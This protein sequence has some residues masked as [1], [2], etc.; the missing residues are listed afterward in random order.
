MFAYSLKDGSALIRIPVNSG[1]ILGSPNVGIDNRI[2][3]G[4]GSNLC[5]INLDRTDAAADIIMTTL[6]G[7]ITT[8][9]TLAVDSAT[10]LTQAFF[11]TELGATGY[12][13]VDSS[14]QTYPLTN[15]A[16]NSIPVL[17]ASYAYVMG[18]T[19]IVWR[20]QWNPNFPNTSNYPTGAA[21]FGPSIIINNL[22][23]QVVVAT[24][25]AILTL[26]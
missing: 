1:P 22:C 24:S 6:Y 13:E 9:I 5:A 26:S 18:K 17:D 11:S 2:Y 12:A 15:I 4:S 19:G 14:T 25:T 20:Y 8:P 10:K 16:S 23:S 21:N 3:F 7:N